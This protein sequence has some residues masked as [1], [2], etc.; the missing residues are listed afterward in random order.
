MNERRER[1]RDG[2]E[3]GT[4]LDHRVLVPVPDAM[5]RIFEEI[6]VGGGYRF[7]YYDSRGEEWEHFG[8]LFSAGF[9]IELPLDFSVCAVRLMVWWNIEGLRCGSSGFVCRISYDTVP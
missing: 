9:E 5:D 7:T 6:E 1:K 2:Y 4:T 3:I 8:H